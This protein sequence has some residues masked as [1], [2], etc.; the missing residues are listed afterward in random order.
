MI[1]TVCSITLYSKEQ[2]LCTIHFLIWVSSN[3]TGYR[4]G[5]REIVA[6]DLE[7][8]SSNFL[9][10]RSP[11]RSINWADKASNVSSASGV[12]PDSIFHRLRKCFSLNSSKPMV[13][14]WAICSTPLSI[15]FSTWPGNGLACG[16]KGT[17]NAFNID[18]TVLSCSAFSGCIVIASIRNCYLR[19]YCKY[20]ENQWINHQFPSS[21]HVSP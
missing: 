8:R 17:F 1:I 3:I 2:F 12:K 9:T 10:Y 13:F 7:I 16:S 5:V 4:K 20:N 21:P 14:P 11:Q 18:F 19:L 15:L 6:K